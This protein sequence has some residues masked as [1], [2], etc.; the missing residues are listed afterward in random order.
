MNKLKVLVIEDREDKQE[1]TIKYLQNVFSKHDMLASIEST[2]TMV[3][4]K[5]Q[6]KMYDYDLLVIDM[7]FPKSITRGT[8]ITA[9]AQLV[10]F[11]RSKDKFNNIKYFINTSE[12]PTK[13]FEDMKL[14]PVPHYTIYSSNRNME[15]SYEKIL[16]DLNLIKG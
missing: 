11:L 3:H 14:D 7:Q 16:K 4:T 8:E 10:N 1:K 15:D 2:I 12:D 9:G 6:L 13:V 5:H